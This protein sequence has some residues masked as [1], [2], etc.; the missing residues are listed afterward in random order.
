M[1]LNRRRFLK[2]G[3][4]AAALWPTA[5]MADSTPFKALSALSSAGAGCL[6]RRHSVCGMCRADCL[7]DVVIEAGRLLR[8][9]GNAAD[10]TTSGR[11]CARGLAAPALVHDPDLLRYPLRRVGERGEGRWRRISWGEAIDTISGKINQELRA[12]GAERL[13]LLAGGSSASFIKELFTDFGCQQ[14]NDAS[15]EYCQA[16]QNLASDLSFGRGGRLEMSF[17]QASCLIFL[18]SHL[19]ENVEVPVMQQ[20]SRAMARGADLI[21]AD[22]RFSTVASKARYHLMLRPGSDNALL[23]AWLKYIIENDLY[24]RELES[25]FDLEGLRARLANYDLEELSAACDL[26]T[27]DIRASAELMSSAAPAVFVYPGRHNSW[28][29]NDVQRLRLKAILNVVLGA[30]SKVVNDLRPPRVPEAARLYSTIIS[31]LQQGR[32]GCLGIWGQNPLQAHTN[33]YHTIN[34]LR[35]ADFVFCCDIYPGEAALYADI[36]LPEAGFLERSEVIVSPGRRRAALRQA[37]LQPRFEAREP[38][39]IVKQ[40]SSR[41]GR[42]QRFGFDS[43]KER[44]TDDLRQMGLSWDKLQERGFAVPLIAAAPLPASAASAVRIRLKDE[45]PHGTVEQLL[46]FSAVSPPPKGFARLLSG[47]SPVDSRGLVNNRWLRHELEENELWLNDRLARRLGIVQGQELFLENQDGLRSMRPVRIKVTPGIRSDCL[48]MA[49][50]FGCQ[51][52]FL[53]AAYGHGVADSPLMVRSIPDPL[54]GVRG[55]RVN[56]VRFIKNGVPLPIPSSA[57]TLAA[58]GAFAAVDGENG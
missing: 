40:M 22:P 1:V 56:F 25:S 33:T 32:I 51:S 12:G 10:L 21:V 50:G 30:E 46:E 38:Y 26:K 57:Q 55:G 4:T 47:R 14:I 20:F 52:P 31:R 34:A 41:L 6:V 28:Y 5:A 29:G 43:V 37:V 16:N 45:L 54:S 19:G 9:E 49:H 23:L 7:I 35:Q 11:L 58:Y 2:L 27:A 17:E 42:G 3:L 15:W 13:A 53:T 39:W 24:N 8:V 48:Y 44:L 18:G 36:I